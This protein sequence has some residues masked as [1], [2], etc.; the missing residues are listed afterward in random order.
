MT[1]RPEITTQHQAAFTDDGEL[2]LTEE[3][4]E[5]SLEDFGADVSHRDVEPRLDR[6]AATEFGVDDRVEVRQ[7]EGSDTDQASLFADTAA[8]QQTLT[9]EDASAQ[10]LFE[11]PK[12]NNE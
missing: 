5:T 3:S 9:G 11:A 4:V 7:L 2:E 8:D 12:E 10:F 1:D 6:P